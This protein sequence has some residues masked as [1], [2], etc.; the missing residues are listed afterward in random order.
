MAGGKNSD[1]NDDEKSKSHLSPYPVSRLSPAF[2]LVDLAKEI[3]RADN[4]L[5]VH[6]SGK[7]E[8]LADQIRN[9]QQEA[10]TI[11]EK[12]KLS[13]EIHR[14]ECGFQKKVG[15]TYHLY[16]KNEK[17]LVLSLLSPADWGER[18]PYDFEGSFR[19]ENDMSWTRITP[20]I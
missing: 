20:D 6:T 5:G 10:L 12:T 17:K 2:D 14:A 9:L 16:R 8:L 19:L 13:Q 7:L 3:A 1:I 11:L 18:L 4:I 15:R